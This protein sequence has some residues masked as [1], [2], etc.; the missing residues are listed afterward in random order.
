MCGVFMQMA[1]KLA[2]F[3]KV[4]Q[5]LFKESVT[6]GY[7]LKLLDLIHNKRRLTI[8]ISDV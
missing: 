5:L 1:H 8:F 6:T 2:M 4:K 7:G 3:L